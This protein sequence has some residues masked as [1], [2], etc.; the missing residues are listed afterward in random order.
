MNQ[1]STIASSVCDEK[2]RCACIASLLVDHTSTQKYDSA[3]KS[4]PQHEK[5]ICS[6]DGL[7]FNDISVL[8]IKKKKT[9]K[10]KHTRFTS[11]QTFLIRAPDRVPRKER[12]E[13]HRFVHY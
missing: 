5:Y 10:N 4:F 3:I 9:P 13:F 7:Q 11:N 8:C 12:T 6:T 2:Q 1:K